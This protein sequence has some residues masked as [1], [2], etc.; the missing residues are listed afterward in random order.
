MVA[1]AQRTNVFLAYSRADQIRARALIAGLERLGFSVWW[2]VQSIPIG[3]DWERFLTDQVAVAQC[4][5]VL[6]SRNSVQSRWVLFEAEFAARRNVLVPA[7]IEDVE[8]SSMF[9]RF[10]TARLVNW[11]GQTDDPEFKRLVAAIRRMIETAPAAAE[12]TRVYKESQRSAELRTE[13]LFQQNLRSEFVLEYVD[14]DGT[15]FH[16]RLSWNVT[17]SINVLLGRKAMARPCSCAAC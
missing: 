2:D 6:W 13:E 15:L 14:L 1:A 11:S 12:Q 3:V 17:P 10:N 7:F 5:V 16:D 8:L 9:N 4:V